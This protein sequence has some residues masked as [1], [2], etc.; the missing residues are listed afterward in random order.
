MPP[1]LWFRPCQVAETTRISAKCVRCLHAVD[2]D[3]AALPDV[4]LIQLEPK[5]RCTWRGHA[6]DK[7]P[8]GSRAKIEVYA[9]EVRVGDFVEPVPV[10]KPGV[11]WSRS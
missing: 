9:P 7:P 11:K 10:L 5:L 3:L 2:L 6:G 4:P 8:C 1:R